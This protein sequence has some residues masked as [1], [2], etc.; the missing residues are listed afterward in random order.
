VCY[1][2]PKSEP[3]APLGDELQWNFEKKDQNEIVVVLHYINALDLKNHSC[4]LIAKPTEADDID[5]IFNNVRKFIGVIGEHRYRAG[6]KKLPM[7]FKSFS[8]DRT[9]SLKKVAPPTTIAAK[10]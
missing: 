1:C 3:I 5:V 8:L 6:D 10:K 2:C 4:T 7:N 9:L